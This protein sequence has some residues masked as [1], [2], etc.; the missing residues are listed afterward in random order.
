M[1]SHY[2]TPGDGPYDPT[3]RTERRRHARFQ[4]PTLAYVEL[5]RSNGGIILN[6]SEGGLSVQAAISLMDDSLPNVRFQLGPSK[7]WIETAA[8][9]VWNGANRKLVGLKFL[10]IPSEARVRI[11]NW[12]A[13]ETG[14]KEIPEELDRSRESVEKDRLPETSQ[15]SLPETDSDLHAAEPV[16]NPSLAAASFSDLIAPAD[17]DSP[18][19]D[20]EEKFTW[21]PETGFVR[22]TRDS[23]DSAAPHERS[24]EPP[25]PAEQK[26]N[27]VWRPDTGFIHKWDDEVR[28]R[29]EDAP[30]PDPPIPLRPEDSESIDLGDHAGPGWRPVPPAEPFLSREVFRTR[31]HVVEKPP[32]ANPPDSNTTR[33]RAHDLLEQRLR[34]TS[35]RTA[36]NLHGE[37]PARSDAPLPHESLPPDY[38]ADQREARARR[39]EVPF[40]APA[41]RLP[42][43]G[44]QRKMPSSLAHALPFIALAVPALLIGW[45]LGRSSITHDSPSGSP[46]AASQPAAV[47]TAS[48][49]PSITAQVPDL[50]IVDANRQSWTIPF[51]P[52]SNSSRQA[53]QQYESRTPPDETRSLRESRERRASSPPSDSDAKNAASSAQDQAPLAVVSSTT[54]SLSSAQPPA[55]AEANDSTSPPSS[56]P[57]QIAP[58][59][60]YTTNGVQRGILI[61]RVQPI[62]PPE[63]ERS[64]IEG[65]VKLRVTVGDD[66]S[67][68]SVQLVS[69]P[70]VLA[71]AAIDAV[72]QWRF[73]PT[74]VDGKPVEASGNVTL[75]FHLAYPHS[76]QS[77]GR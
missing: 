47:E 73:S 15:E 41:I 42:Q 75:S 65:D 35:K 37:P 36:E 28:N 55:S 11:N 26:N 21:S 62:Y 29:P 12:I 40:K 70:R 7:E 58:Q 54:H 69:G 20:E 18:E 33:F 52:V 68:R 32:T 34:D 4:L 13:G 43:Y 67:V 72:Q 14:P 3:S 10:D 22:I 51:E 17:S 16:Q 5:D 44:S 66:G 25:K 57:E 6:L 38:V 49:R 48:A 50:E 9:V 30:P 27:L 46:P 76:D 31:M 71:Q 60:Q 56:E 2:Y 64:G 45:L 77:S 39:Q 8:E 1:G 74:L 61:Y 19:D 23:A 24:G 63:A 59:P 53:S